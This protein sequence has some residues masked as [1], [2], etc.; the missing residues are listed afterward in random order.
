MQVTTDMARVNSWLSL[1]SWLSLSAPGPPR[2]GPR[3]EGTCQ[4]LLDHPTY[5]QWADDRESLMLWVAGRPGSGKSVLAEYLHEQLVAGG[6][7][8][9]L[10][11]F[12]RSASA[13]LSTPTSFA[14][15]LISQ[16]LA[17]PGSHSLVAGVC[18]RLQDF[19]SQFPQGPQYCS[20]KTI[21]EVAAL[22]LRACKARFTI[23]I[24]ALD[25]C[26]FGGPLPEISEFA[27][28]LR[29][30][31]CKFVVFTRPEPMVAVALQHELRISMTGTPLDSDIDA[32]ARARYQQLNLPDADANEVVEIAR[33][34]NQWS[35][36]WVDLTF[37]QLA[38]A[39]PVG[40]LPSKMRTLPPTVEGLYRQSLLNSDHTFDRDQLKWQ[41]RLLLMS[42]QSQ[43][44]L[45]TAEIADALS[46]S[47]EE[48]VTIVSDLCSP[49]ASVSD[50]VL[51][52]SHPS[53]REFF[54]H[55][56]RRNDSSLGISAS[57]AHG[58]L[59]EQCLA[60][61][62]GEQYGELGRIRSYLL[63]NYHENP[64]V[65]ADAKPREDSFY[66]YASEFWD[67]HLVRTAK[68]SARL[69]RQASAF[70]LSRQF[71]YWSEVSR[72]R[73]GQLVQVNAAFTSLT[74]LRKSLSKRR[75][76][77]LQ[78]GAY[79]EGPYSRLATAFESSTLEDVLPWLIRMS[80]GDFYFFRSLT[81]QVASTRK[82][83][84]DGLQQCLGPEHPL[85]LT[86]KSGVAF[87][88][89]Y[90]GNMRA[91]NRMYSEIV[92]AQREGA[93]E[94]SPHC[95]DAVAFLGQSELFMGDF[96]KATVTL[97]K[98]S[99]DCL[100]FLGDE[101]WRYLAAQWWH[102]QAMAYMGQFE[103]A[104]KII[105][106]VVDKR[107]ELYGRGDSFGLVAQ[108]TLGNI[109]LLLGRHDQAIAALREPVAWRRET[110][111]P[112]NAPRID[113]ELALATAYRA[114]GRP[115]DAWRLLME[116]ED[117]TDYLRSFFER[118]CQLIHLSGLLLADAGRVDEAINL[119]QD[120]ITQAEHDQI[121]RALLW[122]CLDLATLLRGRNRD[123]DRDQALANFDNLVRDV[124]GNSDRG[125]PDEPDP[126][127]V[128]HVAEG[129][130]VLV[131]NRKYAEARR[132]LDAEQ[133]EWRRPSDLWLW[134]GGHV[135]T[136]LI[137]M[138]YE[139]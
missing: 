88:R 124:S 25:E 14:S 60:C 126:P 91:G 58:F 111:A 4:W 54:E 104:L 108:A 23:I 96:A 93:G 139:A 138:R 70:L 110:Y 10:Y 52:L 86:A 62:Q 83:V 48:V 6:P 112:T 85:T 21:W 113:S 94:H 22:L 82:Q 90:E 11:R 128:L 89:L 66:K 129:A 39:A 116:I 122:I 99:A 102:A 67:Y 72:Q 33:S 50:G 37:R 64:E 49:F 79:F 9:L 80:L 130:L 17:S 106:S 105:Q 1:K 114:A 117:G 65:D 135:C 26:T 109:Q 5:R 133:L 7:N 40:D 56:E 51:H 77:L 24:D 84:L 73:C 59:A 74:K 107:Y 31:E 57:A 134:V 137:R 131:R 36:R 27:N 103:D 38:E 47:P 3:T 32:F 132:L 136:D 118:Y 29:K 43:R 119:L 20:F 30:T 61:L 44:Q 125:F 76:E 42:F 120:T 35:F 13:T 16:I 127:N 101:S 81:G 87:V 2:S 121:N 68:P 71:A 95:L 97:L 34:S 18:Q 100:T 53:V 69:L 55:C 46:L 75:Q 78:L 12:Q 92:V 98:L 63:V 123:G 45:K 28:L 19:A 41:R 115:E 15:S 8:T